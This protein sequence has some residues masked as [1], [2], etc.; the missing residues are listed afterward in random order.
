MKI[1]GGLYTMKKKK[2]LFISIVMACA[3]FS[4]ISLPVSADTSLDKFEQ[5][6]NS[7]EEI[8]PLF[9]N[10]SKV[11]SSFSISSLGRATGSG[12]VTATKSY[13]YTLTVTIQKVSGGVVSN[14]KSWSTTKKG[15]GS[16]YQ[17]ADYYL[18]SRGTYRL[19]TT[20]VVKNGSGNTI[21]T[22][23]VYSPLKTY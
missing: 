8:V 18:S 13:T 11:T 10:F 7:I 12:I 2:K 9:D 19:K 21:E 6:N 16:I 17:G 22:D 1:K 4:M 23:T 15:P 5:Q 20:V 14:I 3:A